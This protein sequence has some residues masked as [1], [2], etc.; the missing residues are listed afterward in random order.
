MQKK[1]LTKSNMIKTLIKVSVEGIYLNIIKA[2]YDKPI[3]NII[4]KRE[5]LKA[6][7]LKSGTRQERE[8][9]NPLLKAKTLLWSGPIADTCPF[10]SWKTPLSVSLRRQ[11]T[12]L[13]LAWDRI[14]WEWL[15]AFPIGMYSTFFF[16]C[17]FFRAAPVVYGGSQARGYIRAV[18]ASLYHSLNNAG[19]KPD[20][21]PTPELTETSDP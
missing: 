6:V 7:P 4:L 13:P 15:I 9:S 10:L 17:L 11:V 8:F 12:F 16:F 21:Q 5:N 14:V 20:L 3:A 19:S 2:I 1:H 18:A